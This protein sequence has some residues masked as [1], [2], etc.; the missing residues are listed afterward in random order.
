MAD[1][2]DNRTLRILNAAAAGSYGVLAA[3]AYVD[4]VQSRDGFADMI[5]ATMSSSSQLSSP[6]LKQSAHP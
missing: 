3:I 4:L 2:K 5:A 6:Q 1:L